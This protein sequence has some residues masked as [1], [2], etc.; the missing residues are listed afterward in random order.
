M[1]SVTCLALRALFPKLLYHVWFI[2]FYVDYAM[3][4][5]TENALDILQK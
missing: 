3:N 5:V 1:N 2:S 4:P